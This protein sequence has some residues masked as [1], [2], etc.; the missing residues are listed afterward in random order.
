MQQ[1][2]ASH[3]VLAIVPADQH[4]SGSKTGRGGK[5]C[6]CGGGGGGW[7]ARAPATLDMKTMLLSLA[8]LSRG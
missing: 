3:H 2:Q 4:R 1:V 6:G 7:A 8:A 5:R